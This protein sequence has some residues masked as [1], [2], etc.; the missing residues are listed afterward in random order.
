MPRRNIEFYR[1]HTRSI[2]PSVALLLHE[3]L[4]LLQT[5]KRFEQSDKSYPALVFDLITHNLICGAKILQ[6][7][8]LHWFISI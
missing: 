3:Y 1:S 6:K 7:Y 8:Q 4:E 5:V 2:L